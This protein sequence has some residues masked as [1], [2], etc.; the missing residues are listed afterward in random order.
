MNSVSSW[1]E[2]INY[3]TIISEQDVRSKIALPLLSCLCYDD[4]V[5]ANEFPIFSFSGRT[6]NP[7]KLVDILCFSSENWAKHNKF[8]SRKWVQDNALLSFE[9]KRPSEK[10]DNA[11]GQAEFYSMNARTP[12]YMC[13]NGQHIKIFEMKE[14]YKD[15]IIF[16][17]SIKEL[18]RE[19]HLIYNKI[20]FNSLLPLKKVNDEKNDRIYLDYCISLKKQY[21]DISQ[22]YWEQTVTIL[23]TE[24]KI[25][26]EE[27]I[28]TADNSA[29]IGKAGT[30]KTTYL[31]RMFI[32]LCEEYI[33]GTTE[34]I[35]VLL[36]AK[37]WK[38][39]FNTLIDGI[40][41]ELR[42]FLPY[43]TIVFCNRK[44]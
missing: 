21:E 6:K 20:S 16:D 37:L 27:M 5:Q 25:T 36:S 33:K 1:I 13:T 2:N 7:A 18:G 43:L 32:K 15:A 34:V 22:W 38:R 41:F 42:I 17:G 44:V 29:L 11:V 12:F 28:K 9:L 19:W 24:E 30:G 3:N 4:T 40:F 10:L 14:F 35:P 31:H 23:Q 26:V 8:E 39:D